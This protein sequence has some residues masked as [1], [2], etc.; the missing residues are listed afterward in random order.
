MSAKRPLEDLLDRAHKHRK[1]GTV[2]LNTDLIG[3]H[4]SNRGGAGLLPYHVHEVAHDCMTN[5]IH[6]QRYHEVE[7][8]KVPAKALASW[9]AA[10]KAK[11]EAEP[12]MPAY[13]PNMAYA[14]LTHTHF[15]HAMKLGEGGGTLFNDKRIP[16][17]YKPTAEQQAISEN[18]VLAVV[19]GEELW[20]DREA[21]V[22]LMLGDNLNA[23]VQVGEDEVQAFGRVDRIVVEFTEKH[24]EKTAA[25]SQPTVGVREVFERIEND[26]FGKF[27]K[28]T[29]MHFIRLRLTIT[30]Q[31]AKI[32]T[33][34]QQNVV[35][36]RVQVK[37]DEYNQVSKLDDRC[38]LTK[39]AVLLHKY[40]EPIRDKAGSQPTG[41]ARHFQGTSTLVA[42]ATNPKVFAELA[43]E[44]RYA[45]SL[46]QYI[47]SI[48]RRYKVTV[49]ATASHKDLEP[50]TAFL[51]S[52]GRAAIQV[53]LSPNFATRK[54]P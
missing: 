28:D 12:L 4:P 14:C 20:D 43:V 11:C 7:V 47:L 52:V 19:Y 25:G 23:A 27:D 42:A 46:E 21:L 50:R 44:V 30:H 17:I 35:G 32:F 41:G 36:S 26:G 39:I 29:F 18:G 3:F 53:L 6:L 51:S 24:K 40:Y 22:R 37:A 1:I 16:I 54:L 15:T 10:N 49:E 33:A 38:P 2:R 8:V 13:S 48:L 5:H 34:C 9:R 45:T 31:A